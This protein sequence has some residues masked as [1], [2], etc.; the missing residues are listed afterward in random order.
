[1]SSSRRTAIVTIAVLV[2]TLLIPAAALGANPPAN[3]EWAT[4]T[5]IAALPF[6]DSLDTTAATSGV[7]DGFVY[8]NG[9]NG[10]VWYRLEPA[11]DVRLD[12]STAGSNYDTVINVFQWYDPPGAM[13]PN[14]CND[15]DGAGL[16]SRIIA[17]FSAGSVYA[18]QISQVLW[19]A[20]G[21]QLSFSVSQVPP[22][23]NDD[24]D[25]A[26]VVG[27]LPFLQTEDAGSATSAADDPAELVRWPGSN[28]V[29]R[30]HA[31]RHGAL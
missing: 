8:C 17:D 22:P 27:A 2:I 1:M 13:A 23:P 25:A 16:T 21:G 3:D 7:G 19:E 4:A 15:N 10:T 12:L 30:L 20:G 5:P 29:V 11:A 31:R 18:I 28:R 6:G 26:A 14:G 24:F 9:G